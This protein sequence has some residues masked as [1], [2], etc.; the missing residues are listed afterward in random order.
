LDKYAEAGT[1]P[2]ASA[3]ATRIGRLLAGEHGRWVDASYERL[4]HFGYRFNTF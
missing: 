4:R 2:R 1:D 3:L